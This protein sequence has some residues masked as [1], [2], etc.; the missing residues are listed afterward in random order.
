MR[1]FVMMMMMA[2]PGLGFGVP[3]AHADSTVDEEWLDTSLA[4]RFD[5][6]QH[7]LEQSDLRELEE[8]Y[9][10][11]S[12]DVPLEL[13]RGMTVELRLL[14]AYH[15]YTEWLF[16][17]IDLDDIDAFA[18]EALAVTDVQLHVRDA[19]G[20]AWH[21]I[22]RLTWQYDSSSG[23]L[24][25]I[26]D[27]ELR[28]KRGFDHDEELEM[29]AQDL[30]A[31]S[32]TSDETSAE[33]LWKLLDMGSYGYRDT[34]KLLMTFP[35]LTRQLTVDLLG[36]LPSS[37]ASLDD[38]QDVLPIQYTTFDDPC[39][40]I[41]LLRSLLYARVLLEE[42]VDASFDAFLLLFEH[43]EWE[44]TTPGLAALESMSEQTRLLAIYHAAEHSGQLG[45]LKGLSSE[46]LVGIYR[47]FGEVS[48]WLEEFD[49]ESYTNAALDM[50]LDPSVEIRD[51]KT[52]IQGV[53]S[54]EGHSIDEVLIELTEDA[55][56]ELSMSARFA[57]EARGKTA[58]LPGYDASMSGEEALRTMCLL[59]YDPSESRRQEVFLDFVH[60]TLAF[61][62]YDSRGDL[63]NQYATDTDEIDVDG[64]FERLAFKELEEGWSCI[65]DLE[66]GTVCEYEDYDFTYHFVFEQ[67]DANG[68]V[69]TTLTQTEQT[70]EEDC[71]YN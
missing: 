44:L 37:C 8:L 6:L 47:D 31:I 30:D 35:E 3:T 68:L 34:M 58:Y 1:L 52:I 64:V 69:L 57:L 46:A 7:A 23:S 29:I 11:E 4:E 45:D 38:W 18:A 51:K 63:M 12:V 67:T 59:T 42:D 61:E 41:Q 21:A 36:K 55:W 33:A 28:R 25:L 60:E 54:L 49:Y 10:N 26:S 20:E 56:C 15:W 19:S 32:A 40:Q 50:L 66:H 22:R 43:P 16:E 39:A 13:E 14:D 5:E 24:L 9:A 27:E 71:G 17:Y 2:V 48:R 70:K 53:G 65:F 62:S